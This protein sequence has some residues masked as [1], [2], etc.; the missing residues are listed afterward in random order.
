MAARMGTGGAGEHLRVEAEPRQDPPGGGTGRG[1]RWRA[2]AAATL[3][4]LVPGAG[5]LYLRRWRRGTALLAVSALCLIGAA[6]A[7]Q[8]RAG[9]ARLLLRPSWLIALLAVGPALLAFRVWSV[10]DAYRLGAGRAP[11]A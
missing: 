5:Q 8:S 11:A 9:L 10:V 1:G 4:C 3:S 6:I 2:L 7:G